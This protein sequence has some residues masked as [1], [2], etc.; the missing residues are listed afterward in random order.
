MAS[1]SQGDPNEKV[2]LLDL[3]AA[4][5]SSAVVAAD[6]ITALA[7]TSEDGDDGENGNKKNARLK[8]DGSF[9]TDA[10]MAAQQIIV[11]ALHKVSSGIRIVGEENEE[12]MRKRAITGH[13]E[14][15]EAISRLALE[16]VLIRYDR[17]QQQTQIDDDCDLP[18][19]QRQ[20]S[21]ED[22]TKAA[23]I[24]SSEMEDFHIDT[25]RVSVFIDPLD[26]TNSYA[27][28]DHDP[29]SILVAII[30]DQTPC[31]GVI[32]KP[33]GH[34]E[35]T[36]VLDTGCM[37][38]YGGTLLGGAYIAGGAAIQRTKDVTDARAVISQSRSKGIVQDFVSHLGE[39]GIIHPE[40]LHVSGAGEKSLRIIT[41]F[42]NEGL[43]F[44]P[45]GGT[46]LWDVAAS[47]ALLRATGG[48]LTDKYGN[49]M[50]YSKSQK[51]AE[52]K[53]GVVACYDKGLHAECIRLFLDGSWEDNAVSEGE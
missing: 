52:N 35:Q 11:D 19:S 53:R 7:S 36:S 27:K 50:D 46:S 40:P 18:L 28:G 41:G 12:E 8:I 31:F 38:V 22:G 49:D 43:W 24:R 30:L 13:E 14:K 44:Y 48:R 32:C 42:Q 37:T 4:C 21:D 23:S 1:T 10:D 9:V 39:K 6:Q 2:N 16:E 17:E 25:E 15:L 47:D 5:I 34:P 26:A 45:K 3:S 20:K 29:V 33:F 51:E